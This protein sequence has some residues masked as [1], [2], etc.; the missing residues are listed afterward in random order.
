[1][2]PSLEKPL[3]E[4]ALHASPLL[5]GGLSP[6]L[7]AFEDVEHLDWSTQKATSGS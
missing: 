2:P 7:L 6:L 3:L 4:Y 5:P 1:V